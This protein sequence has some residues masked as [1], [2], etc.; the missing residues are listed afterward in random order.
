MTAE[1]DALVRLV[2]ERHP[3]FAARLDSL[4]GERLSAGA[5]LD[6]LVRPLADPATSAEARAAIERVLLSSLTDPAALAACAG[7]PADHPLRR[8]ADAVT[9]ALNAVTSGPVEDTALALPE[10][11]RRSPLAPWKSLLRAIACY[12]RNEDAACREHLRSID[13]AS[14]PA[15]LVPALQ[16]ILGD[17]E[18]IKLKPA[19]AKLVSQ[20]GGGF[21][22]LR[23]ALQGLD[24][25]FEEDSPKPTINAIRFATTLVQEQCPAILA[26]YRRQVSVTAMLNDLSPAPVNAAMGGPAKADARMMVWQARAMELSGA[27]P[28]ISCEMWEVFRLA[29]I[30]ER[31]FPA[32][33]PEMAVLLLHMAK[34][35][36]DIDPEDITREHQDRIRT[37][38][39]ETSEGLDLIDPQL[40]YLHAESLFERAA[41]M[42]PCAEVFER[43]TK[44]AVEAEQPRA[45]ETAAEAWRKAIPTDPRPLLHLMRM[46]EERNAFKKAI[47]YLREAEAL[48][49]V[50]S[51]VRRARLRLLILG[52]IRHLKQRKPH[53]AEPELVE[54]ETLPQARE[55]D[56][57]AFVAAL[58]Y[59]A[60]HYSSDE[61]AML[62]SID[63]LREVLDDPLAARFAIAGVSALC[64]LPLGIL[65]PADPGWLQA[66][67]RVCEMAWDLGFK[68]TP[69]EEAK[70]TILK[71]L[72][73]AEAPTLERF[74]RTV[75]RLGWKDVAFAVSAAGL[76]LG[77][78]SEARFLLI[79]AMAYSSSN[80][81]RQEECLAAAISLARRSGDA[82]LVAEAEQQ[83]RDSSPWSSFGGE[84]PS[85]SQSMVESILKRE[86]KARKLQADRYNP[87]GGDLGR[88][89]DLGMPRSRGRRGRRPFGPVDEAFDDDFDDHSGQED[90]PF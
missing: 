73:T 9:W 20:V 61:K 50:S 21:E 10:V 89:L 76:A 19:A 52:A 14:A 79:R 7:L 36:A 72:R 30:K 77:K 17:G 58:R 1:A 37:V 26:D 34:L 13:P 11:S 35:A 87:F 81:E 59:V 12:Y 74:G 84:L 32:R 31:W 78:G 53:L 27:P 62:A 40:D 60:G 15:R 29:A 69:P 4:R 83:F 8:A 6:E 25:A 64:G 68:F 56:R 5:G 44:W 75:V 70:S 49:G 86:R 48:D 16:V 42:D 18:G 67:P 88:I 24:A 3:A 28:L 22:E 38:Y 55:N 80:L 23:M 2:R 46:A 51:E 90:L 85:M 39:K 66:I 33:G 82:G 41:E 57:P 45:A 65:K 54:L 63:R 71:E 47:G 43:W